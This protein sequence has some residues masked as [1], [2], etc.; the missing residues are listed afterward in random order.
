MQF[1]SQ[2]GSEAIVLIV[3]R[4]VNQDYEDDQYLK[5][6]FRKFALGLNFSQLADCLSSFPLSLS[7]DNRYNHHHFNGHQVH[8]HHYL[9]TTLFVYFKLLSWCLN[10]GHC[11]K[12]NCISSILSSIYFSIPGQFYSRAMIAS[13][14]ELPMA[15]SHCQMALSNQNY[16]HCKSRLQKNKK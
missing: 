7:F 12:G 16:V 5:L 9:C 3:Y 10:F 14:L 15:R 2:Y 11:R 13:Y 4:F 8:I 1:L 6:Y